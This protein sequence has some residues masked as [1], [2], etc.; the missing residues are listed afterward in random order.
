MSVLGIVQAGQM[1]KFHCQ[2]SNERHNQ[3]YLC[4][5][6]KEKLTWIL[7]IHT[8]NNEYITLSGDKCC[9]MNG[10][11]MENIPAFSRNRWLKAS[12]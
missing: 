9:D 10:N 1:S 4:G 7:S 11:E 5:K 2:R 3:K 8:L 6:A 12:T